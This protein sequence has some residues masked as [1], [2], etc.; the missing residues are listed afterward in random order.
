[1]S[2]IIQIRELSVKYGSI[3]ALYNV[4]LTIRRGDFLGVIG[5]N[6]GG[7]TTL[8]RAILGLV[9]P[10]AGTVSLGGTG[11]PA[12]DL[13]IGYV[14]QYTSFDRSFPIRVFDV[15][16]MGMMDKSRVFFHRYTEKDKEMALAIMERLD[17]TG[18]RERQIGQL[19]GGQMQ[20]TLI[21]R[22]LLQ[23]PDILLLDEPTAS[24]DAASRTR[25]YDILRELNKELTIVAVTHDMS[26]VSSH[27]KTIACLNKKLYYHGE[28]A[29]DATL[30][31][32]AYG[33][34]ID[35][36]AHGMP[37]RVLQEHGEDDYV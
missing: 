1:M 24:M 21:A 25:I 10:S 27:V 31:Q 4:S 23:K 28:P 36:L 18:L 3:C 8:L 20:K 19:S 12:T 13:R 11:I 2:D 29:L 35:L 15:I 34:P 16:L 37:H 30:V 6:G 17:I 26:F 9:K 33:C 7:K 5:P 32:E 14:P 22:T